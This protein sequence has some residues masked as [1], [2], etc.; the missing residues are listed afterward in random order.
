HLLHHRK[1]RRLVFRDFAKSGSLFQNFPRKSGAIQPNTFG[2]YRKAFYELP[3]ILL[4]G[5]SG[6]ASSISTAASLT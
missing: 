6:N 2:R 4:A 1:A 3:K 5:Q